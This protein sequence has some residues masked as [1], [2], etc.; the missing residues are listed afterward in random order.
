[1]VCLDALPQATTVFDLADVG[2]SRVPLDVGGDRAVP[3]LGATPT[4]YEKARAP[5][6]ASW[7]QDS[8]VRMT[9]GDE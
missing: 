7:D 1:M 9:R 5:R 2:Q 4:L 8:R 6:N 3:D